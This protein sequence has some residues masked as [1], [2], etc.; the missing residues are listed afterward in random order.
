MHTY[1]QGSNWIGFAVN[2]NVAN[3]F[4][5][6]QHRNVAALLLDRA[7]Q[8]AR[9][10][11]NHQVNVLVHRQQVADFFSSRHLFQY[12][13]RKCAVNKINSNFSGGFLNFG[14]EK[15]GGNE[16][17]VPVPIVV[18]YFDEDINHRHF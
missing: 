10:S 15:K 14:G 13:K 16:K 17:R 4:G 11:R 6:T 5:V 1:F 8:L 7:H 3:A 18:Q 12:N 9:S 2:V